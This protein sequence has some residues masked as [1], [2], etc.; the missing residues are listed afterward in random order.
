MKKIIIFLSILYIFSYSVK[1]ID[2]PR[3]NVTYFIRY[4]NGTYTVEE[5]YNKALD[6]SEKEVLIYTGVT[7]N[8]GI[9]SLPEF[10]DE[11]E[12]RIKEVVPDG[13][14]TSKSE[15]ILNL[16]DNKKIEFRNTKGL[17]N[18]ETGK[19]IIQLTLIISLFGLITMLYIFSNSRKAL[20]IIV[21]SCVALY[22]FCAK[23]SGKDFLNI[24]VK[25]NNGVPQKNVKIEI[26][27]KPSNIEA[28]PAIKFDATDGQFF[29]GKK[30][31]YFK[32]PYEGCS[33]DEFGRSLAEEEIGY[34]RG[35]VFGAY[36]DGKYIA[37]IP[38]LP[39]NLN[40]G[41]VISLE[42][43]PNEDA[44]LRTI[45][46]NGGYYDF[47]GTKLEKLYSNSLENMNF[48][49]WRNF[50]RE[51]LTFVGI[52]DNKLCS[53]KND[54]P[55][56]KTD[57]LSLTD[58]YACWDDVS[59]LEVDGKIIQFEENMT[60]EEWLKSKYYLDNSIKYNNNLDLIYIDNENWACGRGTIEN[61]KM[62]VINNS[63]VRLTDTIDMNNAYTFS[64]KHVFRNF[65]G[66]YGEL[67]DGMTLC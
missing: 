1:A 30:M 60:W 23:A 18:P 66:E 34:L 11:G 9:I 50:K 53:H 31:M 43:V 62:L 8:E 22:S 10:G 51:G 26:Y 63:Q 21:I 41:D 6:M 40:N 61:Y 29:D 59:I 57:D 36:I 15:I 25:D 4:P 16:K 19:T 49:S 38:T 28:S 33:F 48:I 35:N 2:L 45:H 37:R 65:N 64:W 58:Y 13:Y 54:S 42:W 24:T 55:F 47:Y 44:Y 5:D 52:D 7:D 3:D 14:S 56:Y 12:I 39:E 67:S 17:I 32:I 46:L 20:N 27:S